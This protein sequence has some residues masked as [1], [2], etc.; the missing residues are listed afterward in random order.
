M[1]LDQL[2]SL[3]APPPAPEPEPDHFREQFNSEEWAWLQS[4]PDA[5]EAYRLAF[6]TRQQR[7]AGMVPPTY[8]GATVCKGCGPVAIWPGAPAHVQGCP[9]C[10]N[11]ASGRPIPRPR[12]RPTP[13]PAEG[14]APNPSRT[15]AHERL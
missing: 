4:H 7:E 9:W 3:F 6:G 5:L 12:P 15:V 2:A 14:G 13:K 1:S 11:R 10:M 8:T